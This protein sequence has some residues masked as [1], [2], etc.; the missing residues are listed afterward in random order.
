MARRLMFACLQWCQIDASAEF[1]PLPDRQGFGYSMPPLAGQ[2]RG[3]M[4]VVKMR[5]RLWADG[6]CLT[7]EDSS[8]EQFKGSHRHLEHILPVVRAEAA[9]CLPTTPGPLPLA[10]IGILASPSA[11]DGQSGRTRPGKD[12]CVHS[13]RWFDVRC[14]DNLRISHWHRLHLANG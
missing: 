3:E 14:S 9:P 13:L 10:A 7:R 1:D 4:P 11:A 5:H 6:R 8:V 2:L 12:R